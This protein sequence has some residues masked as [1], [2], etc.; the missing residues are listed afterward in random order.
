[1]EN[2]ENKIMTKEEWDEFTKSKVI[3]FLVTNGLQKITLED[4]TGKKSVV[5]IGS[6]GE[7]KVMITSKE[8][9]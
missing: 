8:T 2:N 4:G 7:Y 5:N 1:M 9:L 6:N 3:N